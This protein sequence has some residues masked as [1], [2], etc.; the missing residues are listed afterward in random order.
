MTRGGLVGP[1]AGNDDVVVRKYSASG[2]TQW[3][4]Q[5]GN[6]SFDVASDA[7]ATGGRSAALY[8]TGATGGALEGS[9]H[10]GGLDAFLLRRNGL[11]NKVWTDQ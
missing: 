4:K 9:T 5:F 10:H 8:L 2:A 7:V 6:A 11:G 3:T 1:N